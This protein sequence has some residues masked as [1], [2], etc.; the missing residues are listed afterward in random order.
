MDLKLTNKR[1]VVTGG[2]AGIGKAIVKA[3]LSEGCQVYFCSRQ[4]EN[5]KN[6]MAELS[7]FEGRA[8]GAEVDVSDHEAYKL[9]LSEIAEFD[10]LVPNVS[11]LSGDW[12]ASID[13]DLKSTINSIE[14]A[15]PYLK[16]KED[17]AAITYIGSKAS[18]FATPGF[19]SYGAIKSAM[20][21]YMKSNAK[22][23]LIDGVR[24]NVVSPGDTFVE[25]GFWDIIKQNN[26]DVYEATVLA[27]PMG[28]LSTPD[29]VASAV[30]FLSS[31]LAS[32]ITGSNLVVDGGATNHIHG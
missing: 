10:I 21:H 25:G 11:A 22:K 2:T 17:G 1:V 8:F 5:V 16:D 18:S 24:V 30:V 14:A 13:I 31:P 9:W 32:F 19:E 26:K 29:E 23:Y 3:F 6:M 15:V 7:Q 4:Q 28:R 27:N 12:D 20:T